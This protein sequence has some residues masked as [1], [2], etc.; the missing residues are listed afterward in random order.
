MTTIVGVE[1]VRIFVPGPRF[2]EVV[3]FYETKLGLEVTEPG[4]GGGPAVLKVS[5]EVT[6]SVERVDPG[7]AEHRVLVGRF[8]GFSFGT[9]DLPGAYRELSSAGVKF[10][11]PPEKQH[12][13]GTLA[14]LH[15]PADNVLTLVEVP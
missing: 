1:H 14:F 8:P 11:G 2:Q 13:G 7:D 12:W 9:R 15:D 6:L 4:E 3:S 10:D 5:S